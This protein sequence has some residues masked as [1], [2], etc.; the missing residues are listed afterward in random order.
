VG[1]RQ[2]RVTCVGLPGVVLHPA[3]IPDQSVPAKI[4]HETYFGDKLR[5]PEG[6]EKWT[7][8][9]SNMLKKERGNP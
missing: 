5:G 1:N 4:L 7:D 6:V 8:R 3:V 2:T 9:T